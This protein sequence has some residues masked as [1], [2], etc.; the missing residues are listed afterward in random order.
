MVTCATQ[1]CANIMQHTCLSSSGQS[2]SAMWDNTTNIRAI[3]TGKVR[4]CLL[5]LLLQSGTW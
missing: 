2:G 4:S 3:L 1:A 5:E